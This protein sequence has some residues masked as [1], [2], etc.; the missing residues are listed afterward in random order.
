MNEMTSTQIIIIA[1]IAVY[2]LMMVVIGAVYSKKTIKHNEDIT[3]TILIFNKNKR[4]SNKYPR[5]YGK[6][7]KSPL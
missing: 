4:I 6:I 5:S 3:R 1:T 7:K 2:L